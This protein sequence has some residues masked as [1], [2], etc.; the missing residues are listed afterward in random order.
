VIGSDQ[1]AFVTGAGLLLLPA[2]LGI[3]CDKEI[4]WV[5]FN[6]DDDEFFVEITDDAVGEPQTI[7]LFSNSGQVIVGTATLDPGSGPVNTDHELVVQ[8]ANAWE[9]EVQRVTLVVDSG[10]RGTAEFELSQDS[11][12]EGYWWVELRSVGEPGE[13]RVDEFQVRLWTPE[14]EGADTGATDD[15]S[16]D[17]SDT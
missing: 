3:N 5:Q 17:D 6:G 7:E 14:E 2:F 4:V 15:T 9:D 8:V 1:I 16:D 12:D 11:A 13:T 10:D